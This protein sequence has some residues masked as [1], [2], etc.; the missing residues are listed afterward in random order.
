MFF[1][2]LMALIVS[3][4][5]LSLLC[6]DLRNRKAKPEPADRLTDAFML[7]GFI[8][9]LVVSGHSLAAAFH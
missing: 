8:C 4:L 7:V 6:D 2:S 1:C 3:V 5:M 9:S